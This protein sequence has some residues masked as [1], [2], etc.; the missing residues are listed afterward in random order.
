MI[1]MKDLGR[2]YIELSESPIYRDKER[3]IAENDISDEAFFGLLDVLFSA[4][5]ELVQMIPDDA[6][7]SITQTAIKAMMATTFSVGWEAHKAYGRQST[8]IE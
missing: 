1:E 5:L 6:P 4:F 8:T 2:L 7:D 3:W